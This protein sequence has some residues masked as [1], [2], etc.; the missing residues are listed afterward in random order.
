MLRRCLWLTLGFGLVHV[1]SA[2]T[3]TG[4]HAANQPLSAAN[5][6]TISG[7]SFGAPDQTASAYF[8]GVACS[9]TTWSSTTTL[10]CA[11]GP[12]LLSPNSGPAVELWVQVITQTFSR[13]FTFDGVGAC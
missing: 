3:V 11:S 12:S 2:V 10:Q 13:A 4:I 9:T 8:S 5:Y 6:V 7:L 1:S